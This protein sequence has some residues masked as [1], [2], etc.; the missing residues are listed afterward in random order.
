[1]STKLF[2]YIIG[3]PPYQ[4][5]VE[6]NGRH[7]PVYN[8]FMD[9]SYKV[10]DKVELITPAHFLFNAGQTPKAWNNKML[11]D[12][13]LKVL[14]YEPDA[15]K[16]FAGKEI[17][18]GVAVTIHDVTKSYGSIGTFV[19]D[20]T[21]RGIKQKVCSY[22]GVS[23]ST[24]MAS[25]GLY[26]FSDKFFKDNPDIASSFGAG[27]GN[28]IVSNMLDKASNA[29]LSEKPSD[30]E[31]ISLAGRS[32]NSRVIRYIKREYIQDNAYIDSYNVAVP[33]ASGSG[34][35]GEPLGTPFVL[36]PGDGTTDTFIN[37][38]I[39]SS[40]SEANAIIKYIKTK[41]L[42][43]LNSIKKVTQHNS[44]NVWEYVPLQDF[45]EGS[46]IDWSR[47]VH[48]VDLQLYEK[49]GLDDGEIEF[50]ES[51]VKEME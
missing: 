18:G 35:F 26:R 39:L 49:Y 8:L 16:V 3:N 10:A 12:E 33:E 45:T 17:K 29:F 37:I 42:R 14:Y 21:L 13:H 38:G 40:V 32:H 41:F 51:H 28:K 27:T 22:E 47:S 1:M 15:E 50:I 6:N 48:E 7:S 46:D 31:Y 11:D 44:P 5:E 25:Q 2:D 23:I 30:G 20:E 36:N 43:A 9:E 34:A 24:I 4:E 19:T